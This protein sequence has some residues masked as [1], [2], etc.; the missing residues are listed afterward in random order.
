VVAA[1][2]IFVCVAACDAILSAELSADGEQ[3]AR[4]KRIMSEVTGL[5]VRLQV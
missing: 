2:C 5:I 4:K 1:V 3:A